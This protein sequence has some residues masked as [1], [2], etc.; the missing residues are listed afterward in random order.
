MAPALYTIRSIYADRDHDIE[1][2]S[3]SACVSWSSEP[4]TRSWLSPL[5]GAAAA[6]LLLATPA[7][8][9]GS[10]DAALPH[11]GQRTLRSQMAPRAGRTPSHSLSNS[12]VF[13]DGFTLHPGSQV[14]DRFAA[15]PPWLASFV[16]PLARATASATS[17]YQDGL[18]SD[19][20]LFSLGI[21]RPVIGGLLDGS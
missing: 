17:P 5:T 11:S 3:T 1:A 9:R 13:L 7:A 16:V 8:V 4:Q 20:T 6:G 12:A 18:V 19:P 14:A 15:A 10:F 21:A 2:S